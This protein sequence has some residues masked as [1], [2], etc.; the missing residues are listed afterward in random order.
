MTILGRA[1]RPRL[2]DLVTALSYEVSQTMKASVACAAWAQ[3]DPKAFADWNTKL[4]QAH[5]GVVP[6]GPR[7]DGAHRRDAAGALGHRPRR[8]HFQ[9]CLT[10][11]HPFDDL[12]RTFMQQSPVPDLVRPDAA[13]DRARPRPRRLQER[14]QGDQV[15]RASRAAPLRAR[16]RAT[17]PVVVLGLGVVVVVCRCSE[18][19]VDVVA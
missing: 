8:A 16:R 18:E 13:A 15:D 9:D 17:R 1:H 2:N 3:R 6:R 12:I 4:V 7:R 10:A 19:L 14:R 5:G 11:Y